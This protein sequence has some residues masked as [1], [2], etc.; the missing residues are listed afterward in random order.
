MG[1][2]VELPNGERVELPDGLTPEEKARVLRGLSQMLGGSV[3]AADRPMAP[4]GT[5]TPGGGVSPVTG[6]LSGI[7][8]PFAAPSPGYPVTEGPDM[9]IPGPVS[10][11]MRPKPRPKTEAAIAKWQQL[12][13]SLK[14][15][16]YGLKILQGLPF[17]GEWTDEGIGLVGDMTG[18]E[19]ADE[20]K[21]REL[22]RLADK[23][24]PVTSTLAYGAG[25]L[26]GSLVG[27][28][29]TG[30]GGIIGRIA[31]SVVRG[32]SGLLLDTLRAAGMGAAL[33]AAEGAVSGAGAADNGN[34]A[35]KAADW[36]TM[37]GLFGGLFGGASVPVGRAARRL[38]RSAARIT[39]GSPNI[40]HV[41]DRTAQELLAREIEASPL[42]SPSIAEG[43]GPEAADELRRFLPHDTSM[44]AELTPGMR[45]LL[46]A[47]MQ[48]SPRAANIARDAIESRVSEVN[49]KIGR[50]LDSA[51][52]NPVQLK[53]AYRQIRQEM[54]GQLADAYQRAYHT[55]I[56]Y[57]RPEGMA[58]EGALR[59]IPPRILK[60][61]LREAEEDALA[62]GDTWRQIKIN[63]DDKTG[64]ITF[65]EMPNV[66]QVDAIKRALQSIADAGTDP[67][68]GKMT[69]EAAR[70]ALLAKKLRDRLSAAVPEYAEAV[71][72]AG[73][74]F[75][76]ERATRLGH[77]LLSESVSV[78]EVEDWARNASAAERRQLAAALRADIENRLGAVAAAASEGNADAAELRRALRFLDKKNTSRKL[79]AALG[80]ETADQIMQAIDEGRAALGLRADVSRNSA[81]AARQRAFREAEAAKGQEPGQIVRD[82][83]SGGLLGAGRKVAEIGAG[84]APLD[85]LQRIDKTWEDIATALTGARGEEARQWARD[86][87]RA[88][89]ARQIADIYG[90]TASKVAMGGTGLLGYLGVAR[91][92]QRE[93]TRR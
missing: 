85:R 66:R 3:P 50:A 29:L 74:R 15:T 38:A 30:A 56:D 31:P 82:A 17:V 77:R 22:R 81:T 70:A 84:N 37:G 10:P 93:R 47:A 46:D 19:W 2:I 64:R 21:V 35:D 91:E 79:E 92:R 65:E 80:K 7:S 49:Q 20:N 52:G 34:R 75:G 23:A 4:A 27:G 45:A 87:L 54:S 44:P 72:L 55:P 60:R 59:S 39:K 88:V 36:A 41:T 57:S 12:P 48:A 11:P 1:E 28:A 63:I 67:Q 61:A 24:N 89:L 73:D 86:A 18:A 43:G 69:P 33:G 58:I 14:F 8:G 6:Q 90:D 42:M 16:A 40:P 13:P 68:T 53:E 5:Q 26:G 71:Q 25:A 62:R 78:E 76:L 9:A 51:L 83:L 32:G